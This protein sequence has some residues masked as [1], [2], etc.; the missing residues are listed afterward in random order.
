MSQP[1]GLKRVLPW[2]EGHKE[3]AGGESNLEMYRKAIADFARKSNFEKFWNSQKDRYNESLRLTIE[4]LKDIDPVQILEQYC[5]DSQNS[6]NVIICPLSDENNYGPS[7][8]RG[9]GRCDIYS[10]T[11]TV[12]EDGIPYLYRESSIYL[13][14]HEFG[15]S[16]VNPVTAKYL[17]EVKKSEKLFEPIKS[18]MNGLA[19]SEWEIALNEH[20]VRA[21]TIR[22]VNG[23]YSADQAEALT[24][25][26]EKQGFV[27]LRQILEELKKYEVL[28]DTEAMT[29][30]EYMPSL[31]V[32]MANFELPEKA[33]SGPL[34]NTL[35]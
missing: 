26:E 10:L 18:K 16:F 34:N 2:T 1:Y 29:L 12:D 30:A 21:I 32:A 14:L 6:Y 35:N 33:L 22:E 5:N 9:N 31:L 23:K 19:Y 25:F 24:R 4:Q 3:R 20:I 11:C 8:D 13:I 15:H 7:V 27:Y 28:R 17:N